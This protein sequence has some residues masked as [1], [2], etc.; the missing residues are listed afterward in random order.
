M[1]E[2]DFGVLDFGIVEIGIHP[3]QYKLILVQKSL[4]CVIQ[5]DSMTDRN[6]PL[7]CEYA[8]KLR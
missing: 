2:L 3:S 4:Q 1:W 7:L 8:I 6:C 5:G